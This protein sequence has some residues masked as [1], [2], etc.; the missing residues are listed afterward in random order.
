VKIQLDNHGNLLDDVVDLTKPAIIE[1]DNVGRQKI[2]NQGQ[3]IN[4]I[5]AVASGL[6]NLGIGPGDRVGIVSVNS[7]KFICTYYGI[8]KIGAT[9]VLINVSAASSQLEHIIRD[10]KLKFIF[11]DQDIDTELPTIHFHSTFDN[12]LIHKI[13]CSYQPNESDIALILYTSG[14]TGLPKGVL[15]THLARNLR[16]KSSKFQ[17]QSMIHISATPCYSNS[18]LFTAEQC[19]LS[20][21][22]LVLLEKFKADVFLKAIYDNNVTSVG[23][24]PTMINLMYKEVNLYTKSDLSRVSHVILSAEPVTQST[25]DAVKKIFSN[26]KLHVGYGSTEGGSAMF[27]PH[28]SLSTPELSVG[29][30]LPEILYRIVDGILQVKSPYMMKQYTVES[31]VFTKDGYYITND[32]FEIDENGFYYCQGRA[33]EIFKSGGNKISPAEIEQILIG[34]ADVNQ[35]SIVAVADEI[36]GLKPYAFAVIEKNSKV[37]EQELIKYCSQHLTPYQIPRRIWLVDQIPVNSTGKIDRANLKIQ[38]QQL[39]QK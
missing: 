29:Y 24:L 27:G 20:N 6:D 8:L 18:G 37:T 16:I 12:F 36:K 5:N 28:P 17:N 7:A 33:D 38:A 35:V 14:S 10:S 26:A 4:L 25:R 2:Y 34:H 15:I 9:A 11:T 13:F 1:V 3:L 32:L 22:P 39:V 30:P 19:L 31:D 21:I 23:A